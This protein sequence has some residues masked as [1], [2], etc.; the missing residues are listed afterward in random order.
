MLT[1]INDLFSIDDEIQKVQ[2]QRD[3]LIVQ[4]KTAQQNTIPNNDSNH[5]NQAESI[6]NDIEYNANNIVEIKKLKEKYGNLQIFQRLEDFYRKQEVHDSNLRKLDELNDEI[7]QLSQQEPKDFNIE[8][9]TKVSSELKELESEL[10][11]TNDIEKVNILISDFNTNVLTKIANDI[12]NA[13]K[14]KLLESK[15][16]T[17]STISIET[18]EITELRQTSSLLYKISDLYLQTDEPI[19]WNFKCLANN[20][21]IRFIYHFHDSTSNIETYF[22]YLNEYLTTNLYKCINLFHDQTNGLTKQLIHEQF[23]NYV[24]EPIREKVQ[25]TLS[26]N[27]SKTLIILISQIISTDKNLLKSFHYQGKGLASL[28]TD[29]LWDKWIQFEVTTSTRQFE[30]ITNDPN[31]LPDTA[32]DF[33]KLLNKIYDYLEPFYDL[34]SESIQRYKLITCSQIFMNLT[35]AY[36]DYVL[37]VDYL[38]E[39]RTKMQELYQ[40]MIKMQN[41]HLVYK[42]IYHLSG[43]PIFVHLTNIVNEKESKRYN[44]LFQDILRDYRKNMEDDIQNSIIHRI[45]KQIKESLRNYFKIG[46]WSVME[47]NNDTPMAVSSELVTVINAMNEIISRLD[48]LEMPYELQ[49]NIK[50]E[51]LNIIVNYFIESILKLNKFNQYGLLQ[52]KLDYETLKTTLQLPTHSNNS[53]DYKILRLLQ[54]LNIKYDNELYSKYVSKEYIKMANFDNLRHDLSITNLSDTDIQDGL[55]RIIYGNII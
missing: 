37:T 13:F 44:S 38:G 32:A 39:K 2:K 26:Q 12:G 49:L 24:L 48:S 45:Q 4:L 53:Q 10:Q 31:D 15:W 42:K 7:A 20:F 6:A 19:L 41:L 47:K 29:E 40:T 54:I 27:D 1:D 51:L 28:L 14:E 11:S 3:S 55:Y 17:K 9:L 18:K 21:N 33:I 36:L 30:T 23:I 46:S 50:N 8:E 5:E 25:S 16:D 35:S 52:F 22:R 43:K 34:E